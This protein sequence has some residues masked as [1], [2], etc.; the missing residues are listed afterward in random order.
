[1]HRILALLLSVLLA[2]CAGLGA[3]KEGYDGLLDLYVTSVYPE[4]PSFL[5]KQEKRKY[6]KE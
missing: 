6:K 2:G 5:Y 1:M 3:V 4:R